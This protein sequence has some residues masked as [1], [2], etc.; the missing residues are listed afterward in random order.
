MYYE[1]N[2][3]AAMRAQEMNSYR[4]Y[5]SWKQNWKGWNKTRWI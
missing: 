1:I 3:A 2:E 5:K 4:D